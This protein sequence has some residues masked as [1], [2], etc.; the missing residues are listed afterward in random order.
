MY[1]TVSHLA[2]GEMNFSYHYQVADLSEG[3]M[4]VLYYYMM[5]IMFRGIEDPNRTVGE[6]MDMV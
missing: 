1:L 4:E 2:G 6:I 5:R 3:D